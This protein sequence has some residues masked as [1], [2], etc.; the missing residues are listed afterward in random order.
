VPQN[1]REQSWL[2]RFVLLTL[3][4]TSFIPTAG[5]IIRVVVFAVSQ[6]DIYFRRL[7]SIFNAK[8]D[9]GGC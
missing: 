7:I 8:P 9:A 4:S 1:E 5:S 3:H 6:A 2:P